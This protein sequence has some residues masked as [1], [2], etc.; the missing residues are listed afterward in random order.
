MK[1]DFGSEP[2]TKWRKQRGGKETESNNVTNQKQFVH[3]VY[4]QFGVRFRL[5]FRNKWLNYA[6]YQPYGNEKLLFLLK[7][8]L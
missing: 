1:G 2:E 8:D 6:I 7:K 3:K 5:R 4:S